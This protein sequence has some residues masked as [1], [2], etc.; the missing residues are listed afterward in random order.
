MPPQVS[1][2]SVRIAATFTAEPLRRVFECWMKDFG[3]AADLQFAPFNQVLQQLLDPSSLLSSNDKGVNVVLVRASDL[4]AD[5]PARARATAREV[6]AAL[7]ESVSRCG[8]RFFVMAAPSSGNREVERTFADDLRDQLGETPGVDVLDADELLRLY[9]V[10]EVFDT[11]TAAAACIPYREEWFA[12]L[13]TFLARNLMTLR[14][15]PYKV[16]AVDCDNTLWTG[17]CGE[18]GAAGVVIDD[19]RRAFQRFLMRRRAEGYLLCLVSKNQPADVEAVFRENPAMEIGR[20]CFVDAMINWDPKSANLQRLAE[21]L[22]LGLDSFLFLDDNPA[23]VAEVEANAPAVLALK[24]PDEV[25]ELPEFVRHLWVLDRSGASAEDAQ[26]ADFYHDEARRLA[27]RERTTSYEQFIEGLDLRMEIAP[28][29]EG[30]LARASQLTQRTN[31]FNACPQPRDETTL[32]NLCRGMRAQIVS[33]RDRFGDYGTVGLMV[34]KE[35][36]GRL[37]AETFLLS[38]R[39]LGKGVEQRMLRYLGGLAKELKLPELA[40]WFTDTGR[41]RPVREFLEGIEGRWENGMRIIDAEVASRCPLLPLAVAAPASGSTVTTPIADSRQVARVAGDL[42]D[43]DSILDWASDPVRPRPELSERFV[44]ASTDDE[45]V[46]ARIWSEVLG[47]EQVGRNDRF[48]DLG[49]TSLQLVRVHAKVQRAFDRHFELVRMFENPTVATQAELV[50]SDRTETKE[51]P[52]HSSAR[53]SDDDNLLAIVGMAVRLPGAST[54]E[55]LWKN[56]R[57]GVESITSF[58]PEELDVPGPTDDPNFVRA[59]GLLEPETYEGLDGGLFGII[60][61]EAEIIDPQQRVFLELCWEAIERAGYVPDDAEADGGRVGIYAGC[62]YDTYL[63]HHILSDPEMHRRHLAEAQVGA[64]QVEFGN[65]KDHL[66]TRVAFKLNLKGPSL[67]VQTACSSSL[68]AVAHAAMALRSG[69]CDMALAGGITITVPQKR[70]YHHEEGGMLSRDGHCRPF[71]ADSSG[72]VFSNGGGVVLLK[73]LKDAIRDGDHVHA[74]IRGFGMNNDGGVKHSYAAPSV[75]GQAD[76]IRRA[77]LDAGIDPRTISYVEAHGTATPLG[78][79]IE[80]SGLTQAF[81]QATADKGFCAIGSLKSNLGHL[82]TAAGVCGLIKT[83][84]SLE[85]G[86]LPPVLHFRNPNPRIDFGNSPFFVND[87][88]RPWV[89]DG[90]T[91]R[92]AGVSSFG[93]GGTNAHVILEEAPRD[94]T[95]AAADDDRVWLLSGR[96]DEAVQQLAERMACHAE[97]ADD[98]TFATAARTLAVGRK[99]MAR[100]IAVVARDWATLSAKL[101]SGSFS[102]AEAAPTATELVWMFPGQGAQHPGMTRDLYEAE[103]GYRHDIDTCAEILRPLLGEDL[104]ET[105]FAADGEAAERLKRTVLAQPAIFVVEWA[106]ARQWARWGL[107]PN[108]MLGHSVGEFTAAC[109]AGVF[110]IEDGLRILAERGRLMGELP[111]GSMLSVRIAADSLRDRLPEGIDLA[112]SNGPELSVVAGESE[113][114]AAFAAQL[115]SEGV[116]VRELHTSHAFH[117]WMMD[118]VVERF[119]AV[120]E[121]VKLHP[122]KM[123]I[124]STVTARPLTEQ[125]ATDPGYWASHLR[126]TVNFHGAVEAASSEREGR[127]FLEVGPGQTL[128]TLARQTAGRRAAACVPTCEHPASGAPDRVRMLQSLGDLWCRGADVDWKAV[129]AEVPAR[130]VPLP[131][132]PFQRKRYWKECRL[133]DQ[134]LPVA[135]KV[136]DTVVA[137]DAAPEA[138]AAEMSREDS[139]MARVRQVLEDLSGIPGEE[140]TA[141]AGFLEL[142]FDSL[143]LTQAARELQKAFGVPIAFRDLM[144]GFPTPGALVKHLEANVSADTG[145]PAAK[146][147]Q[148]LVAAPVVEEEGG[149]ESG[150]AGPRTRI[151]RVS[152]S[153]E[154]APVQRQH[155]DALVARYCERTK[156][157][158]AKTQQFRQ[159]HADPRTVNGFNR[160]WKEMVYQIVAT[161]MKGCKMWDVDGNEYIDMVNGFGPNFLGHSPDFVTDAIQQQLATG[162]EIGPQCEAAME[163]SKLFCEVTGNERACFLNT[164]SEAV[165]AAMRIA[166]TVTGRD[167]ILVFDK[168]YHG[169]FDPVLVRSVGKGDRRRTLPLAPGIPDNAV[170]DV[171]VV[172]WGKPEALD[173]IREV[174]DQ[175]AAVLVEP[176][177]SRQPEFIPVEFVREVKKISEES[178]FLLVFDEVITGIRQ[179]PRGAQELYGIRADLATYGKVFGGGALPIGIVGGKAEYMDTFDGGQWQFGD[180]SFPEKE[181]TFFAGTFVR[182]PLAM[183]ACHAVLKHVQSQPAEYWESIGKRAD[184]LAGTV[185]RMFRD[186]GIDVR[187]VNFNSQMY[188]RIGDGAKHGN[189]IYYHLREKGVFA[190]EGLPFYLTAAHTDA[191]VDF[192]INAFRETID[193]LQAGG[194]FPKAELPEM[195]SAAAEGVRGPFPMTEPMSE[196]YLASLLGSEANLAFNEMLQL[197]LTGTVDVTAVKASI[198]D[199]VDRHDALRMRV[200]DERSTAFV[201]DV[202]QQACVIEKDLSRESDPER[203]LVECGLQQRETEF[204]LDRGPVFRVVV[205]RVAPD[206]V[207]LQFVAHHIAADGWSFE[208]LIKEF[209]ACYEARNRGLK[210][211]LSP[212]PSIVDRALREKSRADSDAA[213]LEWWVARFKDGVPEVELPLRKGYGSA[214]SYV[215][216]T[217]EL[218]L[219]ADALQRLKKLSGS[220]GATLNSTLL[221][222]F[223]ALLHHLGGQDRFV[224]TFPTAGQMEDGDS[225]LVGHCVNFLPL[226]AEVDP[227]ASFRDLASRASSAQMDALE[228]GNLT[229]GRLLRA[230]KLGRDGGRRPLME[231]IFN[232]EP[233]G[234]PGSFGGLSARVETVPARYSNSTIFLNLMQSPEGLLLSSTYNRELIDEATM[235]QWLD[236]Y[237]TLLLQAAHDPSQPLAALRITDAANERMLEVW[238]GG[239]G[240]GTSESVTDVFLKTCADN[241]DRTAL[242][243]KGG[244]C[245]YAELGSRSGGI[246]AALVESGVMPGDRVAI[247]LPRSPE[248]IASM[249]G[250]LRAG[251]CYVPVEPGFPESRRREILE[252]S[253]VAMVLAEEPVEGF[254]T[255]NPSDVEPNAAGP[256]TGGAQD[257]AYVMYTSGS[258]GKPKGVVVPHRGIVRLVRDANYCQL[259][260]GEVLL[261][262]STPAFDAST[263]EIYGAL[264]NGGRLVLL[265]EADTSL[266]GIAETV[267]EQGVTTL[268]LTSGLFELMVDEH[269]DELRGLKQLIAGGDVLSVPHVRRAL[270]GLPDTTL[271][272]GYGPT[273]N[274]TFT[275]CHRI[276]PE[277]VD[278]GISIPIGRPVSGTWVDIVDGSGRPVPVGVPGELLCG[279]AG[280]AIGYLGSDELTAEKFVLTEKGRAYRTGDRCRWKPDG[281]VEFLGRIDHQVKLRG[282]RI[283]LGEIEAVL[284]SHPGVSQCRVAVRGSGASEKRLLVWFCPSPGGDLSTEAVGQWLAERLPAFMRPDR[285]IRI[286]SMPLNAN[287]KINVAALPEPDISPMPERL[288]P[289]GAVE[290]GLARIWCDLLGIERVGRDDDFFELGGNSLAGLRMFARIQNE[291]GVSLPLATLLRAKTIRDL[292]AAIGIPQNDEAP[293]PAP[294]GELAIVQGRGDQPAI[295]AI[296]GG[297]GGI[298]FYRQLADRLPDNRPFLAIE[299][300][301]LGHSS[302]IEVGSVEDTAS[303]YIEILRAGQP[304]GPYL[305]AG[306]SYG[307]VVAFEMARQ[308]VEAG[309][310]VPFLAL[311]DTVN[312]A[313]EIRPYALG[314]RVSVYWNAQAELPLGER[315]LRLANRFKNGVETH[316]RVK[317]ESA[318]AKGDAASA[319][320]ERRAVQLREAHE[321]AMDAYRPGFFHGTLHVFRASAVNDKFEIPDDYGWGD[322]VDD[323]KMMVVP[324]EHLTMFE[325]GN[326]GPLADHVTAALTAAMNPVENSPNP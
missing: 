138:A 74:V 80:I 147:A 10:A 202:K 275:C 316:L 42:R 77:H 157:S 300:P 107:R 254:R 276:R 71:D 5:T 3:V 150:V 65:D 320:T 309:E 200:P 109:L 75:D 214:P 158:K 310:Q 253:G 122:P 222:G 91:P 53:E 307:G 161:R 121:T 216:D 112:A 271:I 82:D 6:A 155:L 236:C 283:E 246:A 124:L 205:A 142:G 279:G 116:N 215:S 39:A 170:Q 185:D 1:T 28:V 229:Y 152:T 49:G 296:H 317:A 281:T 233:S 194:F 104:R 118:P 228:H 240:E 162:L 94:V 15:K 64:L 97:G 123:A 176:V 52:D 249:L 289:V 58:S 96:S 287:G 143:L 326:V 21:R 304:E 269:L 159:W 66:A 285:I 35:D 153:D 133:L 187:M 56:L 40:I 48:V 22:N 324:G 302:E 175:L 265:D 98:G 198:Q 321:A 323:L 325:S 196:I 140:M 292:A 209:T 239:A 160:L 70:G 284:G 278:G 248:L 166:R 73:R 137:V 18:A 17:V 193:E 8:G 106:L 33:V 46:I 303:R 217:C 125:E 7:H 264:L 167:K 63:P 190:M 126:R 181:V 4:G 156:T 84:L 12:A 86:E 195:A 151:D 186:H 244:S 44:E 313:T 111:G 32:L 230:L 260:L 182:L 211:T 250:V 218:M 128:T 100:R 51:V 169:N 183:A 83:A 29:G 127:V 110:S 311:F 168:D 16:I 220:C 319:H 117:S 24:I 68:V 174:A 164:G 270:E 280:L 301:D 235:E 92:R 207:V 129:F 57:E 192:V 145:A 203:S 45:R 55:E 78:D 197:R 252:D 191:D 139:L 282:Y 305:L 210:P 119:R 238:S 2:L 223:Q 79:P 312:P 322:R 31:Q 130:R 165:Q 37:W 54:P 274:T 308:L 19:A 87:R 89:S 59:R 201:I 291:F 290:S 13:A 251:A 245:S 85:N 173:M 257:A 114:V 20:D 69:Q 297:D 23:E 179:G 95:P 314:E 272:N 212:A 242:T 72:T 148:P 294:T 315:I 178:G 288:E 232:F 299:S 293:E 227:A 103:R 273:E 134:P 62:Y 108:L 50:R 144:Q 27:L 115:E 318:A 14:R 199:L 141:N 206:E 47:L 224:M 177:Q 135:A 247:V 221:A 234:D 38:C 34:T 172:P 266:D 132:Y 263:F 208:V 189:L 76:A 136:E 146:S 226:L 277:D 113:A 154:L 241:P 243:W 131:T 9:P 256:V 88:L 204:H 36:G 267:R 99:A 149:E 255:L 81:R 286:G 60:P 67:T 102:I 93:V 163:C 171:I 219:D 61:R 268:W 105:L 25:D 295:C 30:D 225:G 298:L 26:R 120:I 306:Y 43:V 180:D 231:V 237:R 11:E 41:N 258:T 262:A 101:R 90:E 213:S 184:R 261:Q 188:L 259:G